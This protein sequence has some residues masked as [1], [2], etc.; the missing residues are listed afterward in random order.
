[1]AKAKK[2]ASF[3]KSL[4]DLEGIVEALE[5]GGLPLEDA[6]KRFEEGIRLSRH[7]EKVLTAAEKK[8]EVLTKNADG[9]LEAKPFGEEEAPPPERTGS[10]NPEPDGE[11]DAEGEG[12][13]LLF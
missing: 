13:E 11:A 4:E 9:E 5:E 3:E 6:L 8:I 1:M 2:E 12:D 10:G 7:C